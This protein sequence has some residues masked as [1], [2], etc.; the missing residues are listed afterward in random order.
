MISARC[1]Y[2]SDRA[3]VDLENGRAA[4]INRRRALQSYLV[5]AA[6]SVASG[7]GELFGSV[8]VPA[9]CAVNESRLTLAEMLR[10]AIELCRRMTLVPRESR[11][12]CEIAL[13]RVQRLDEMSP[14][15]WQACADSVARLEVAV[16]G[17]EQ[18]GSFAEWT[19]L[20]APYQLRSLRERLVSQTV[21]VIGGQD[22]RA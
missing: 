18:A 21:Q 6:A 8:L 1:D 9:T 19:P 20:A 10:D 4:M 2:D 3:E 5:L 13:V 16:S 15:F 22:R 17:Y 14:A 12:L 11:R 7:D